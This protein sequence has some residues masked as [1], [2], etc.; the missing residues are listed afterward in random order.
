LRQGRT[1]AFA[2]HDPEEIETVVMKILSD[3]SVLLPLSRDGISVFTKERFAATKAE[4]EVL[5]GAE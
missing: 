4:P 2:I 3:N 5:F 1:G